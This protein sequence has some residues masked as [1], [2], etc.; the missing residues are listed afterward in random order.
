MSK[1][2]LTVE[3]EEDGWFP[4]QHR[5]DIRLP[6][7]DLLVFA[8]CLLFPIDL[9]F[10]KKKIIAPMFLCSPKSTNLGNQ[11]RTY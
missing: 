7:L 11:S 2:W 4:R 5:D 9:V 6:L 3:H 10:G 1:K 8:Y